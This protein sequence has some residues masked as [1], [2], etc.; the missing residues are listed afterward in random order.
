MI[1]PLGNRVL[2]KRKEVAT[3]KGGILLPQ[4]AQEKQKEG[5]VIAVGPGKWDEAGNLIKME[6]AVGDTVLF[7]SYAGTEVKTD[8]SEQYMIM[9]E[10]EILGIIER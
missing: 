6:V 1:Q 8:E 5:E 3:S 9:T 10:E 4:S 7:S 2:V